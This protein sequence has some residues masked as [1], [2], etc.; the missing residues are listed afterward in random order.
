MLNALSVNYIEFKLPIFNPD[1]TKQLTKTNGYLIN[2]SS[3]LN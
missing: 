3:I 1:F 2:Y